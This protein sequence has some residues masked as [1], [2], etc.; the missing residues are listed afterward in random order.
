MRIPSILAITV[1]VLLAASP[2]IAASD[3][4]TRPIQIVVPFTA[5]GN[6]D[7]IARLLSE[8]M[9]AALKQPVI[10]MNRPGA[11]TNIG[12]A[13]VANAAPDGYTMLLNAPAS[14]VIN[15]FIY[16][17]LP[18]DPDTAFA[19]V[20]LA[21]QFPNVLVVNKSMGVN[22]IQELI[23]KAKANPGKVEYAIAGI[24]ATSHLSAALFAEMADLNMVA[25]PYKGTSEYLPDLVA[26]RVAFA[27]DNLG[28][29]L[30]FINSG[31]LVALGVSTKEPVS[32]LPGVP[33]IGS[34]LKGYELSSWNVLAVPAKTPPDVVNV[35]SK[36][37]DRIVHLPQVAEKMRSFG[38]EPVGGTPEQTAA[39]LKSERPRWETAIK[40]AKIPK[41]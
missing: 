21:A 15:Q 40:A 12:A 19:P 8:R 30:P 23:A 14:F 20:C 39:F 16:K 27:I 26:G 10:V 32:L 34:V 36:E 5:G 24:G 38:S 3:F 31:Q 18:Y 13:A 1:G 33:P 2:S 22:S 7:T 28:P 17:S 9:Q 25:V 6:T 11:G 35:L 4:P 41:Q 37:C 29:I